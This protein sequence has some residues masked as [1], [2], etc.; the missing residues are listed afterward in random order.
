MCLFQLGE[1]FRKIK[2]YRLAMEHYEAAI[3]EIPDREADQKKKA[4][5][6]AGKLAFDLKD[7]SKAE[8]HLNVLAS[9][10]FSYR[11]VSELLSKLAEIGEKGGSE[12]T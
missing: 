5:Y 1:C 11:D 8:Q 4:Y 12:A 6:R 7:W 2:Q 9:L 10:D 3:Q